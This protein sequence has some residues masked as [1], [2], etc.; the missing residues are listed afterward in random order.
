[1][2]Q[3]RPTTRADAEAINR[4]AASVTVFSAEEVRAVG[5]LLDLFFTDHAQDEFLFI[6]AEDDG[7][8]VGFACYGRIALTAR[9]YELNWIATDPQA[10]RRGVAAALIGEVE[11]IAREAGARY[12][13]LETSA[14]SPY[15]PARAF[16]DRQDYQIVARIPDYY[17]DGDE[18]LMYRKLVASC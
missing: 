1:M 17:S 12:V 16:Y 5:E 4:I 8:V 18:M 9:N 3:V 13:N 10:G 2:I 14:T 11:R 15:A 7:R 6:S